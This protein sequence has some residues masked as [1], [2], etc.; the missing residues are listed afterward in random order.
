MGGV[1]LRQALLCTIESCPS[2]LLRGKL[3]L[4]LW[5]IPAGRLRSNYGNAKPLNSCNKRK[6][7]KLDFEVLLSGRL[8]SVR[9]RRCEYG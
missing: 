4:G 2:G 3:L 6:D 7:F 5:F 1:W 9:G 8:L